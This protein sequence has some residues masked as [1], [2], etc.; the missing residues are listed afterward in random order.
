ME[1]FCHGSH[2]EKVFKMIN[3]GWVKWKFIVQLSTIYRRR[4]MNLHKHRPMNFFHKKRT[5]PSPTRVSDIGSGSCTITLIRPAPSK[6][7]L[8]FSNI[9]THST[10]NDQPRTLNTRPLLWQ[11]WDTSRSLLN[12]EILNII[13]YILFNCC[14]IV[15]EVNKA[16][17]ASMSLPSGI[18]RATWRWY[19]HVR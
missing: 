12:K 1:P 14:H 13:W 4:G 18:W 10:A 3:V 11:W 8:D 2:F 7:F 16:Y 17:F 19:P 6:Y 9:S 15:I 5:L